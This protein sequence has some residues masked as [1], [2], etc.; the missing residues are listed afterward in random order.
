MN[1][2]MKD[3]T[4]KIKTRGK[5]SLLYNSV[6][7]GKDS[8]IEIYSLN[9]A[10]WTVKL[11]KDIFKWIY[12]I[13]LFNKDK[14]LFILLFIPPLFKYILI[15]LGSLDR[16]KKNFYRRF[17]VIFLIGFLLLIESFIELPIH[18]IF[19]INKIYMHTNYYRIYDLRERILINSIIELIEGIAI[20]GYLI[21]YFGNGKFHYSAVITIILV[22]FCLLFFVYT[23]FFYCLVDKKNI[24]KIREV[25]HKIMERR[26]IDI[27]YNGEDLN[28]SEIRN[29]ISEKDEISTINIGVS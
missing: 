17:I 15:S 16:F 22:V 12:A 29:K 18:V 3:V 21:Y 27:Y 2:T 6:F 9:I 4:D 8:K 5:H 11:L 10:Y 14:I 26:K 1:K 7:I 24:R 13:S 23:L 28:I 20:L 25:R 19:P